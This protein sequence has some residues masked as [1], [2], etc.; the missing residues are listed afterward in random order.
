MR[1]ASGA[2]VR[3]RGREWVVLPESEPDLLVLRPLGGADGEI[4]GVL[5]ALEHVEPAT[6]APPDPASAGDAR[7]AGLL[8]DALRLGFR[9]SA[10]PF[11][12][13][14]RIAVDPRPYQLVPL[15]MALPMDPV[16]LLIADD[17]GI[18]KTVEAAL[19][20]RELLDQGTASR[21]AVLCPPHLAE[22]WQRELHEKFHI[23]AKVVLSSTARRLERGLGVGESLF[24]AYPFVV[25]ST[26]YIKADRRRAEF[27][28]SCPELVVVDE[29]HGFAWA[30]PGGGRARQQRH[31]LLTE[32]ARDPERHLVLVTATPH[33]GKAEAFRSLLAFLGSDLADLPEDLAGAQNEADRRR[34]ARHLVQRRRA[35][36]R[37]FMRDDTPFPDRKSK[38]ETYRLAPAQRALLDRVLEF[39][40]ETVHEPGTDARRQRIR[41]WS[42][43]GL[44]RALGSSPR[45][46]AATL[47]TRAAAAGAE[48]P[49]EIDELGR[50]VVLDVAGEDEAAETSDVV[51]GA[52]A[53]VEGDT[54]ERRRLRRFAREAAALEGD[55]DAKLNGIVPVIRRL[56][57][58]GDRPIVFCRFIATAEYLAEHLRSKLRGTEVVAV[59]GSLPPTERE[60][61]VA[62]L[63]EHPRRVLVATDCLSEGIN[64]QEHFDLV[65]HYDLSWNPT[66]HEQREGRVDRFGQRRTSVRVVT[67]YGVD[68]PVDGVVL[69]VLLRKHDEIRATLGVSVPLPIESDTVM[70]AILEGMVTRG[71]TAAGNTDQLA[72]FE[73][74]VVAPRRRNLHAEWDSLAERERRSRT[75]F[76]HEG[77]RADD[78]HRELLD[79]Q[80]AI[81]LDLDVRRFCERALT[82][83]GA[84]VDGDAESVTADLSETPVAVRDALGGRTALRGRFRPPPAD[85]HELLT[86]T[87]PVI[88]GLA[89]YVLDTSLDPLAGDPVATRCGVMRTHQVSQRTTALL[90]RMRFHLA[91]R[92]A[93]HERRLLAEDACVLAFAGTPGNP[94][95]L[96][97]DAAEELLFAAPSANLAPERARRDLERAIATLPT[98]E[99]ALRDVA[100]VRASELLESHRRVRQAAGTRGRFAV[101]P[102][103]PVDVLGLY[104]F[105]PHPQDA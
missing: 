6:F 5:P 96:S 82:A 65:V 85:G 69:N 9:S 7:S 74:E 28:R 76:A 103:L 34:L 12:S 1:F 47:L 83:L 66:R 99:H 38:D 19:I 78:V 90:L 39:A 97:E 45:A 55:G 20:A 57:D 11:R 89:A 49:E 101:E 23:D 4:A 80:R 94:E 14:G 8:R 59:T 16:R 24:D 52:D 75:M 54:P 92:R 2:L 43:L 13:F 17:V 50:R 72:L 67:Y 37:H 68:N 35:D 3:A 63:T 105:L 71:A 27:V 18:G 15:L 51:P 58:D 48:T 56:L 26:E 44:L 93:E 104:V 53:D 102:Q 81:G 77:I 33:S 31:A 10:G 70:E 87:H 61:R 91:I 95:W 84:S 60:A 22:Q 30:G 100:Q 21:L 32:L 36:I 73:R 86:R 62:D 88:E 64:L 41:W 98:L 25:V 29:A 40:R 79:V 46:A 42:A